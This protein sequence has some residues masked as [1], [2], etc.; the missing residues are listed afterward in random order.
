M[1]AKDGDY[2]HGYLKQYHDIYIK[3]YNMRFA[4][5]DL[6]TNTFHLIIAENLNGKFELLYKTNVPVKLGEGRINENI[7]IPDAFQ[8]GID[9]LKDFRKTI[10]EFRVDKIRA[11]AT[12]AVRSAS[13]GKNFVAAVKT[14]ALIDIEIISGDDEARLIYEGVKLSGAI[15]NL[16]LIMDIGGGSIE[17]IL[18]NTESLIWKK[19]YNIGA[20]R[21][22]Q[23]FFKSDPISDDDKN[24][25]LHHVQNQ[26]TELFEICEQHQPK[27]LIGSAGAFETFAEL[28][29]LK[30]KQDKSIS[31][32]T[33][34]DFNYEDYI[35]TT[36]KIINSTHQQRAEM[37]G[38][39]PLRVDMIVIAAL[40]TNYV[41]GR[42]KI[43]EL[44][45][46]TYDLKMG[47]LASML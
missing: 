34:Y 23:Q 45:L 5:I 4:V 15:K 47:V 39:I 11:T 10:D 30:N 20:A 27:T 37:Q 33:T 42:L 9:A 43:N 26:L 35:H 22:L 28:V 36:L 7:I 32:L 13:N 3:K 41:M 16:S 21:L 18:C 44:K 29:N 6:G 24:S 40:I 31:R 8:R 19:S 17:F 25:I 14:E 2:L 46:S 1:L 38:I 12:S